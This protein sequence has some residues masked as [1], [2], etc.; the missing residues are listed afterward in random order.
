M[1]LLL[2]DYFWAQLQKAVFSHVSLKNT[3]IL[4]FFPAMS[5]TSN[6]IKAVRKSIMNL[7]PS[8]WDSCSAD[9]G[10]GVGA[11]PPF[12]CEGQCPD[13]FDNYCCLLQIFPNQCHQ[14][15]LH[16][17]QVGCKIKMQGLLLKKL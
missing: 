9:E 3:S 14:N 15:Q 8:T 12:C 10:E 4:T 17:W 1:S 2:M 6:C 7:T 11:V 13:S 16:S 5:H